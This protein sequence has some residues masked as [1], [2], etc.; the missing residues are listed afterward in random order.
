MASKVSSLFLEWLANQNITDDKKHR[1]RESVEDAFGPADP[2]HRLAPYKL[3]EVVELGVVEV[4]KRPPPPAS[5]LSPENEKKLQNYI[6]LLTKK[7][8]FEGL[9]PDTPGIGDNTYRLEYN[10]RLEQAKAKFIARLEGKKEVNADTIEQADN[11]KIQ[12]NQV[13]RMSETR[14]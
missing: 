13:P 6:A 8:L 3:D 4:K 14:L 10:A 5:G 9:T 1:I 2:K 12:G 11:F 7:G